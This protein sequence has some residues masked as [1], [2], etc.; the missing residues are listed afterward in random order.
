[1]TQTYSEPPL[2]TLNPLGRFSDRASHYALHRPSYPSAVIDRIL[3]GLGHPE[4]LTGADVGA[5][6]GISARLIADR[7]VRVWAIEPNAAMRAAAAPHPYVTYQAAAAEETQLP[8]ASVDLVTSF[9]AFHWFQPGPSLKEFHRI[10]K[11]KGRLALVW[12]NRSSTDPFTA[13][14][15]HLIRSL[16]THHPTESR[17]LATQD[18]KHSSDYTDVQEYC[19]DYQ[20]PLD[21]SSLIGCTKSLSYIPKDEVAQQNLLAGLEVLHDRWADTKG[22]VHMIYQTHVFLATPI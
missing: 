6:T 1:M 17:L 2:H 22:Y 7:G 13:S 14:Y 3:E 16:S 12:N 8:D 18:L 20:Q 4:T 19:F 21:L 5:G 11:P 10:L 15:I 9:Q